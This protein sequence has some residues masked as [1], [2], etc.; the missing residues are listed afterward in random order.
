MDCLLGSKTS[1]E[2]HRSKIAKGVQSVKY[3]LLQY[4]QN[5]K[6]GPNWSPERG[7]GPFPIF[8]YPFCRKISK[9][10]EG[11]L[12]EKKI[13]SLAV[14]KKLKGEGTLGLARYKEQ[15]LYFSFLSQMVQF[16]TINFC[17]TFK[18]YF[19]QFVWIEKSHYYSRVSLLKTSDVTIVLSDNKFLLY[20]CII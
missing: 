8:Q 5:P 19:V 12:F 11:G 2:R 14:P 15:L 7:M 13:E 18:N 10:I 4:H 17:R 16:G 3:S 9:K 20:P 6:V 1:R